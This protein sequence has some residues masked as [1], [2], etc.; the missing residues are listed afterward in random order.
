MRKRIL[1]L[2]SL[3]LFA[4][5]PAWA[6]ERPS[7]DKMPGM[8]SPVP[9]ASPA[10]PSPDAAKTETVPPDAKPPETKTSETKT[11]EAAPP[12]AKMP[13]M[14]M[15]ETGWR[16]MVGRNDDGTAH[17]MR[18]MEARQMSMGPHMKMTTLRDLKPGDQDKAD[19]V[20]AAARRTAEKYTDYKVALADGYKIFLP[21]LPQKQY[22]F[23]NYRYAF[24]AAISFNPEHPTSLLYEKQGSV[25]KLIGVMYTAPK[26]AN[27]NELDQR[28]PLSVAQWHAH[29]NLCMP[30]SDR[31]NEAWGPN[32][33]FG[34]AGS[35]VTRADC[36]TAGGKFMPQ[37]FGWMVHVYPFEQRPEAIWSVERQA[38]MD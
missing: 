11:P 38:H 14:E 25:Y 28:I 3:V 34:L 15:N 32:A 24:E 19:E 8:S 27:W 17:A 9:D 6:Q 29:I 35:I 20:I 36:D 12:E 23:T 37:I 7:P 2:A 33:K 26:N 21:N 4:L 5:S 16:E 22:H 30:P 31:R 1:A 18:S 10:V 13:A